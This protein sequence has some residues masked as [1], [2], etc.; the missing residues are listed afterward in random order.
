MSPAPGTRPVYALAFDHRNS[1]RTSFMPPHAPADDRADRPHGGSEAG[2]RR[3]PRRRGPCRRHHDRDAGGGE[4]PGGAALRG[5]LR[6]CDRHARPVLRQGAGPLQPP[7]RPARRAG[8]RPGP[9]RPG[10]ARGAD[11]PRR[12]RDRRGAPLAEDRRRRAGLHRLRARPYGVVGTP[13]RPLA[14]GPRESAVEAI[15]RPTSTS[16]TATDRRVGPTEGTPDEATYRGLR[17]RHPAG[18]RLADGRRGRLSRRGA[19]AHSGPRCGRP[20]RLRRRRWHAGPSAAH[21]AGGGAAARCRWRHRAAARRRLPPAD[22]ADRQAAPDPPALRSR[23][24]GALRRRADPA[25]D[26]DRSGGDRRQP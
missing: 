6:S 20:P 3:R 10:A 18:T 11:R 8:R 17:S 4:R 1:F 2:G 5:R 24:P 21:R 22:P 15:A 12:R 26:P 16:S 19:A 25:A 13:A 23:A 14:G 9:L 7:R